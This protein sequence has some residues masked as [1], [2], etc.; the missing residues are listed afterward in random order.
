MSAWSL[1]QGGTGTHLGWH[2]HI[3]GGTGTHPGWHRHIQGGTPAQRLASR[4]A[5][6]PGQGGRYGVRTCPLTS[7]VSASAI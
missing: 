7:A 2:R 4:W 6:Q 5:G 3:Q 1:I